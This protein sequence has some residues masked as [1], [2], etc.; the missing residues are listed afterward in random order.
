M[1]TDRKLL[2]ELHNTLDLFRHIFS[3]DRSICN[4]IDTGYEKTLMNELIVVPEQYDSLILQ[5]INIVKVMANNIN[6]TRLATNLDD[7]NKKGEIP[8]FKINTLDMVKAGIEAMKMV[9]ANKLRIINIIV[10]LTPI[11]RCVDKVIEM[12]I[13]ILKKI[14][15][16]QTDGEKYVDLL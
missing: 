12:P 11:F 2:I 9:K 6:F 10:K 8:V 16:I 14:G 13:D 5:Y 15:S 3:E 7:M 1:Q 4:C